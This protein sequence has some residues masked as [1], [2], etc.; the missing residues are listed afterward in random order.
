MSKDWTTT[1]EPT[2]PHPL[3]VC[4]VTPNEAF[5][6]VNQEQACELSLLLYSVRLA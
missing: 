4:Q 6:A 2:N 3:G 5:N 1:S